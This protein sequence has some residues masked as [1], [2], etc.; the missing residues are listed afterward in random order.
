MKYDHSI[1]N[2]NTIQKDLEKSK[3]RLT[4]L[5]KEN[6][7]LAIIK[8]SLSKQNEIQ[9]NQLHDKIHDL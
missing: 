3:K 5:Q 9:R 2:G 6:D 1:D 7:E 4:D 8:D